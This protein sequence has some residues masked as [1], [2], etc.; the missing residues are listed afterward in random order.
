MPEKIKNP[1]DSL[2]RGGTIFVKKGSLL[3]LL[4]R[5]KKDV[6]ILTNIN[7]NEMGQNNKPLALL[8]YIRWMRGVG[9]QSNAYYSMKHKSVKWWRGIFNFVI[10][11]AISNAFVLY[12]NNNPGGAKS[13]L[14][15]REQLLVQLCSKYVESFKT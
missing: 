2:E 4:Y 12:K 10:D 13:Q 1:P 6:R 11:S 14:K 8:N 9:N 15:F 7:G 5:D 3:C